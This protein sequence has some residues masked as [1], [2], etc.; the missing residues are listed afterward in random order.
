[1]DIRCCL[2]ALVVVP[3]RKVPDD[4]QTFL[5]WEVA[6]FVVW[7]T[8]FPLRGVGRV[9]SSHR[10]ENLV[11]TCS[12]VEERADW[13]APLNLDRSGV[14]SNF[15]QPSFGLKHR[16]SRRPI[17]GMVVCSKVGV[18]HRTSM[19]VEQIDALGGLPCSNA[20]S[21]DDGRPPRTADQSSSTAAPN[22]QTPNAHGTGLLGC[23]PI[24]HK[25][26]VG[27]AGEAPVCRDVARTSGRGQECSLS[28]NNSSP[29]VRDGRLDDELRPLPHHRGRVIATS[30][31]PSLVAMM[32]A[33]ALNG[34]CDT[35][36]PLP[37]WK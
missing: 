35:I 16:D 5:S 4:G 36:R 18:L 22:G 20:C 3:L 13:E 12:E 14:T 2:L 30:L 11:V 19:S 24:T 9:W 29:E 8:A 7:L 32:Y 21:N 27:R 34:H 10:Q 23:P 17:R 37:A 6:G 26:A 1:M 28:L 31:R 15:R 25:R 33:L